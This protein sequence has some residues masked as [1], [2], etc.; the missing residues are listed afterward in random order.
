MTPPQRVAVSTRL[1]PGCEDDYDRA[2][3]EVP[4][5]L[6]QTMR[7]AGVL[8][9]RIWR[10]GRDVFQVIEC[11]DY[12]KLLGD[13]ADQPV[14]KAWQ[15]RMATMQEVTHDYSASGSESVLPQV[16][17]LDAAEGT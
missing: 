3:R 4:P 9:W 17:D 2:H 8:S 15:E 12:N 6:M 14:N 11:N 1:R 16:W 7:S 10:S 5:E 13:L